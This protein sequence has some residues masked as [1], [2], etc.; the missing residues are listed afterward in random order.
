VIF[1]T[2]ELER[3]PALINRCRG[4]SLVSAM[5]IVGADPLVVAN[6]LLTH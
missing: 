5:A 2:I 1:T 6:L 3:K 4:R